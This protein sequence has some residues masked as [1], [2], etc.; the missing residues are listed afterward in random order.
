MPMAC[1]PSAGCTL[2]EHQLWTN[3]PRLTGNRRRDLASTNRAALKI[4]LLGVW[5][6]VDG[7]WLV[8]WR[9]LSLE[10]MAFVLA[11]EY[12]RTTTLEVATLPAA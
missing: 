8:G 7:E 9:Y 11:T 12:D 10:S 2:V 4:E 3:T 1:C 5:I 6:S